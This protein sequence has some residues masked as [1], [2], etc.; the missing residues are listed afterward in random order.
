MLVRHAN[1]DACTRLTWLLSPMETSGAQTWCQCCRVHLGGMLLLARH[2]DTG[3]RTK[4]LTCNSC[5]TVRVW[6]HRELLL[7]LNHVCVSL[8]AQ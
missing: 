8:M 6:L 2:V 1:L 7:A 3:A 4:L 5:W